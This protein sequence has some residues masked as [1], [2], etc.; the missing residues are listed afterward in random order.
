MSGVRGATIDVTY[1]EHLGPDGQ[2]MRHRHNYSG[3]DRVLCS[4]DEID[5]LPSHPKG[6]RYLKL[7]VRNTPG[8]VTLKDLRLRSARYPVKERGSFRC[9]DPA[10]NAIW[11]MGRR[12]E[13]AN[14]EDAYV[15]CSGRERGMYLRDTIIQYHV[16]LAAFGD[17][18]LYG[19]CMQLY[20]QSPDSTGKF[21]AVYP[22]TGDY[23]ISDFALNGL[24]GYLAYY[25]NTGDTERIR[26]D[27][28]A[29]MRNLDWFHQLADQRR[30]MLLDAEWD[31]KA[32][33]KAHYGGFHG[34]LQIVKGHM[35]NTGIHC[36]FSCTYLIA[37]QSALILA[38]AIGE[39]DD[40]RE[41]RRRI[42]VL[43]RS[44]SRAFWDPKK[45]CFAD[46]QR[47]RTHSIHC[48]LF[49]VRAGIV[50]KAQRAAIRE[51]VA[52]QLHCLFANG[53][54][55]SGGA[56][57]SPNFAFYIL[58]GLYRAGLTRTAEDM[59]RTGWGWAL[60]QG[61]RTCPEYWTTR[62]SQCHA[63]SASPTYY[64]SRYVLGVHYPA[65]PDMDTVE[66]RVQTESVTQAEG[67][68]PHPRGT[69][70]VKWHTHR[71][72]RVFDYVKA[73]KGVKVNILA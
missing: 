24:E 5:W 73:P 29:M 54:D 25:E 70:R 2:H 58:D 37:M 13:A 42:A 31:R 67:A 61:M 43:R 50:T 48:N 6:M 14:M 66:I 59:M 12:T 51:Y 38:K 28:A 8:D 27:W 46:N 34:D 23:T 53:Y 57:T 17:H 52:R 11:E 3:G 60:S 63:W 55:P 9:S 26:T 39:E 72:K 18:A 68:F 10:F 56:Y 49:P 19:R 36:V 16:N 7:T 20:G 40:A 45:K 15:D 47:H 32:G 69:V 33:I 22:N 41:L 44:I 71:G 62:S 30:D 35:D 4:R 65:A 64:L 21:R 1:S